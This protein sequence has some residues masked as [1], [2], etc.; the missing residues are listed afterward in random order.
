MVLKDIPGLHECAS[1]C[2]GSCCLNCSSSPALAQGI[3]PIFVSP[4]FSVSM[5]RAASSI[6]HAGPFSVCTSPNSAGAGGRLWP[7]HGSLL[8]HSGTSRVIHHLLR[9]L[10]LLRGLR[11]LYTQ[12][13]SRLTSSSA[14]RI[15][16]YPPWPLQTHIYRRRDGSEFVPHSE[17]QTG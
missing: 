11:H 14:R 16:S 13:L 17:R 6:N 8:K 9:F 12:H 10:L 4:A 3:P 2:L 7:D 5:I 15:L 1:P